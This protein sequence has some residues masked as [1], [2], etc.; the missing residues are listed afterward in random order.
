MSAVLLIFLLIIFLTLFIIIYLKLPKFGKLPSGNR[1]DRI[2]QSPNFK[3]GKFRNVNPTP[4]L[5][6]GVTYFDAMK[7]F[8]FENSKNSKPK[9]IIP[10]QKTDLHNLSPDENVLVWFGHSSYFMQVSGKKI[11]VDPVFSGSASPIYFTTKSFNGSDVYSADDIPEID[12]LFISHDHWDHLD[13]K[14]ISKLKH[15]IKKIFTGLGV[16]E[17]LEY[18]GF[19]KNI[20]YEN[21]W[22]E[23]IIPDKGF[24]INTVSA[25]H[26]SGR[27]FK[28]CP[29]IWLSFAFKTPD[30]NIF[31]G[32]DSGYDIHFKS[33]GNK[34]GP[35]DFAILEC[36]QYNKNWKYIHMMPEEV[37]Q[38]S[39]DLKAEVFMPVHWSKF[40]LAP[41]SWD[42]PVKRVT[43]ESKR[44]GTNIIHPMIGQKVNLN[45]ITENNTFTNWW[46][47]ID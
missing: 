27:T 6:E 20:I 36:G 33:I 39:I 17:H 22:D 45:N 11:L 13:F 9:G 5:A 23:E 15:K 38:A 30:M 19:D 8:L 42:E 29:V 7:E 44:L 31:I 46:E 32:G 28:R 10:S 1:L 26:F 25:R 43:K 47:N 35:F 40:K 12:Y 3:N 41:H 4:D 2:L 24:V 16:G 14:T 37:V 18:W 21:D 34:F